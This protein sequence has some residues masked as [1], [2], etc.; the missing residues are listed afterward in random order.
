MPVV[1]DGK[2]WPFIKSHGIRDNDSCTSP[3]SL[4]AT[5]HDIIVLS[6]RV[7]VGINH[8]C[9]GDGVEYLTTPT[10]TVAM[11]LL[12]CKRFTESGGCC[13]FDG[14]SETASATANPIAHRGTLSPFDH[15][16]PA[17]SPLATTAYSSSEGTESGCP[18][19]PNYFTSHQR[20]TGAPPGKRSGQAV[21]PGGRGRTIPRF[22]SRPTHTFTTTRDVARP[23]VNSFASRVNFFS[24]SQ[25]DSRPTTHTSQLT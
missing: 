8:I 10:M 14:Q 23:R 12:C 22:E 20:G 4:L 5:S 24:I 19:M 21:Q 15:H 18:F 6:W 17:P 2:R 11:E 1:K 13:G 3:H 7:G 9:G 16:W 25:F